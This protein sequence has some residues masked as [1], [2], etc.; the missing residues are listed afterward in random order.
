MI[1]ELLEKL[2]G[3]WGSQ[4]CQSLSKSVCRWWSLKLENKHLVNSNLGSEILSQKSE[5]SLLILVLMFPME[6]ESKF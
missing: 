5:P 2:D 1:E 6:R 3:N 4:F